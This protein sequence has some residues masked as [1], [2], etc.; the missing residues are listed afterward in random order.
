MRKK[1]VKAAVMISAGI[2]AIVGI[3]VSGIS[4]HQNK[5]TWR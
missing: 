1:A 3:I 5:K 2:A 4:I